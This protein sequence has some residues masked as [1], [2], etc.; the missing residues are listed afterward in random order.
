MSEQQDY[1]KEVRAHPQP[2]EEVTRRTVLG[3]A[4]SAPAVLLGQPAPS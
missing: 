4:A 3:Y 1:A 2:A